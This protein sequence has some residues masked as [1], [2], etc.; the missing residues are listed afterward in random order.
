[1]A[2][3]RT[4]VKAG[5]VSPAGSIEPTQA[6]SDGAVDLEALLES[7][8]TDVVEL[9]AAPRGLGVAV[10][11]PVIYDESERSAITSGVVVLAIGI[12]PGTP[13]ASKLLA[14]AEQADASAV[15][16]KR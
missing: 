5:E 1:M 4:K 11:E 6:A 8:G 16:F 3:G 14:A 2:R 7:L 15:I 10:G 13:E 9:L 12:R